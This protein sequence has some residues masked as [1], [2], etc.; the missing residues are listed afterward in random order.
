MNIIE[1]QRKAGT[2]IIYVTHQMEWSRKI[3]KW[4]LRFRL[5]RRLAAH[6]ARWEAAKSQFGGASMDDIFVQV[7][8]G[9]LKER[10]MVSKNVHNLGTVFKFETLRTFWKTD[11]LVYAF[12]FPLLIGVLAR[13]MFAASTLSK[14]C[15]L[16]ARIRWKLMDDSSYE[17]RITGRTKAKNPAKRRK[18]SELTT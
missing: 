5:E 8:G 7:Y 2:T 14:R 4:S 17:A 18:E 10:L 1:E 13:I 6:T 16:K 15:N 9:S 3:V 12:R 11:V